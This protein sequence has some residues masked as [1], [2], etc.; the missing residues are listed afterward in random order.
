MYPAEPADP[1]VERHQQALDEDM[2]ACLET[3]G[4]GFLVTGSGLSEVFSDWSERLS[5]GE[6]QR[7]AIARLLFQKPV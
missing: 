4:L 6:Q 1:T 2:R 5:G 3:V 7:L